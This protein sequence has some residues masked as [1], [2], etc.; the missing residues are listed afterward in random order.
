MNESISA[1]ISIPSILCSRIVFCSLWL[2]FVFRS[3]VPLFFSIFSS[4]LFLKDL[5][6]LCIIYGNNSV[7]LVRCQSY[8][9]ASQ[10]LWV[11]YRNEK[12][13]KVDIML[14]VGMQLSIL[15]S[16]IIW[17]HLSTW[18]IISPSWKG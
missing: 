9:I 12:L 17:F 10:C 15:L 2:A 4:L 11:F 18:E 16:F 13:V 8:C 7:I 14:I 5:I 1:K 6:F 3:E